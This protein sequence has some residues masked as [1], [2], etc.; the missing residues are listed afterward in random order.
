MKYWSDMLE[1][2]RD[3]MRRHKFVEMWF[4]LD[5][6]PDEFITALRSLLDKEPFVTKRMRNLLSLVEHSIICIIQTQLMYLYAGIGC[7][8][9]LI[10]ENSLY[11]FYRIEQT[12]TYSL[13]KQEYVQREHAV[14]IIQAYWKRCVCN[15][16]YLVC[17]RRLEWEFT[18]LM[19]LNNIV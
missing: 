4:E 18:H 10:I 11:A 5:E 15:P 3:L 1:T 19:A 7:T 17:R 9:D 16:G 12:K 2:Y 6:L 8:I 14:R 13:A